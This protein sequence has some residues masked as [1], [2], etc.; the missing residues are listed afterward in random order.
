MTK[1]NRLVHGHMHIFVTHFLSTDCRLTIKSNVD[2]I[3]LQKQLSNERTAHLVIKDNYTV[4]K[5][6]GFEECIEI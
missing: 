3:R 2:V 4:L 6:V 5:E 1:T